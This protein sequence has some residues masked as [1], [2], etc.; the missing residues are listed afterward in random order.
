MPTIYADDT[1]GQV[2][3]DQNDIGVSDGWINC[4]NSLTGSSAANSTVRSTSGTWIK[5]WNTNKFT[6]RRSFFAFDTS[7][8]GADPDADDCAAAATLK[9]YGFTYGTGDVI[10]VKATAPDLSTGVATGDF[11][12]LYGWNSSFEPSDLT[13]YSDEVATWSTS[14]YND[15]TL[16]FKARRDMASLDVFKVAIIEYDYDYL[17]VE[18]NPGSSGEV[19]NGMYYNHANSLADGKRP[20]IDYTAGVC[21]YTNTVNGVAGASILNVDG[22]VTDSIA[23]VIGVDT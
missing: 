13:V 20:Y 8:V 18:F 2:E 16:N 22:V 9:I 17:G 14:G 5:K 15:I 1:D 3:N 11:N 7:A 19:F 6:I 12:A 21:G 23:N 10:I 4:R